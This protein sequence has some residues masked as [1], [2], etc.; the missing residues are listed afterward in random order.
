MTT[1]IVDY[2]LNNLKSIRRAI[3]ECKE[4][5]IVSSN[6][7]ELESADRVI[8]PGVGAF[9]EAMER[10]NQLGWSDPLKE[11]KKPLLGICLGMQLLADK[12]TE[13][14]LC[15]GL[16]LIPGEVVKM[17]GECIPHVGWNEI[18]QCSHPLFSS[19]EPKTDFYF[20]HS[21]QFIPKDEETI[22]TRTPYHSSF[23]SAVG[24]KKC[25]GVQFHPEKSM[26]AGLRLLKNFCEG[27]WD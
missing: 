27:K 25:F 14:G 4:H 26:P 20:V 15:E 13:G 12:G 17:E 18:D 24:Y 9:A 5:V 19:I 11:N 2:Q 23:V 3:E 21:Y 7:K 1:L 22:L 8:L 16:G 6:P 10:L